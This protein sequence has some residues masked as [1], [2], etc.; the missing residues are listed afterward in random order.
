[1]NFL[2]FS[3]G[4]QEDII[5]A[6]TVESTFSPLGLKLRSCQTPIER[7]NFVEGNVNS[8]LNPDF[9]IKL[10]QRLIPIRQSFE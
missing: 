10:F 6:Y 9:L 5:L 8:K 3:L 4:I 7:L 2:S 1:M